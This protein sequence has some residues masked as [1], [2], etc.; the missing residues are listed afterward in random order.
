MAECDE[1]KEEPVT[2][3]ASEQ[4]SWWGSS[5]LQAAKSK[6]VEVFDTVRKDVNDLATTAKH[7]SV[8]VMDYVRKDFDEFSQTFQEEVSST[9]SSVSTALKEKLKMDENE[10]PAATVKKS[11]TSF[12]NQVSDVF[13]IPPE[14]DDEPIFLDRLTAIIYTMGCEPSTFLVDPDAEEFEAWQVSLNLESQQDDIDALMTNNE[15][16]RKIFEELVPSKVP[17]SIFWARYL[18]RIHVAREKET[19]RLLIRKEAQITAEVDAK[20]K[21]LNWDNADV[22]VK[23][24]DDIPEEVQS[25]LLAEYEKECEGRVAPANTGR[26]GSLKCKEKGDMVLVTMSGD[27]GSTSPRSSNEEEWEEAVATDSS[28]SIK[29][30]K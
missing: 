26:K 17:E 2:E 5:W 24:P 1:K 12:F 7:K 4:S 10:G 11:V 8:E 30:A 20:E 13:Y 19:Q 28:A 21:D 6:S 15:K 3:E 25:K 9:A 29:S 16:L 23:T 14:D 18:Y 27:S 22:L